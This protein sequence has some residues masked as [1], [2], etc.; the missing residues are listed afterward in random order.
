MEA[1]AIRL[2]AIAIWLEAIVIRLEVVA[3]RCPSKKNV[4]LSCAAVL[5]EAPCGDVGDG[6]EA[7]VRLC[8]MDELGDDRDNPEQDRQSRGKAHCG[9]GKRRLRYNS[10]MYQGPL[11]GV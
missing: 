8:D 1:S 11:R 4:R 2:E 7:P 9:E 3:N 10:S 5:R 6:C